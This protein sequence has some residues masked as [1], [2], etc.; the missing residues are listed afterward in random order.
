VINSRKRK[1]TGTA[2]QESVIDQPSQHDSLFEEKARGSKDQKPS[3]P[4]RQVT[5]EL[6]AQKTKEVKQAYNRLEEL[7]ERMLNGEEAATTEWLLGAE[8]LVE[9]FRETRR[10]FLSTRVRH[11]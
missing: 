3:K 11:N 2:R 1:K 4:S 10:L 6:E 7:Q 9:T 8:K 5:R